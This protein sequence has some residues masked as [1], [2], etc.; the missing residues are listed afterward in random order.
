MTNTKLYIPIIGRFI[1]MIVV[2]VKGRKR[3]I[4]RNITKIPYW[5]RKLTTWQI[6][7]INAKVAWRRFDTQTRGMGL[8]LV[9]I[10]GLLIVINVIEALAVYI[11]G[12]T[13]REKYASAL[14]T[15]C[16]DSQFYSWNFRSCENVNIRPFETQPEI[17]PEALGDLLNESA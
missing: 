12:Y 8:L 11:A 17:T 5:K 10:F 14:E 6:F 9:L 13:D 1:I 15:A 2:A 4:D 3:Y 16:L 7:K